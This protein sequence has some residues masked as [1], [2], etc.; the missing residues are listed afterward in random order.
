MRIPYESS[1]LFRV[2]TE[3]IFHH[4]DLIHSYLDDTSLAPLCNSFSFQILDLS[5]KDGN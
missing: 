1:T 4:T 3:R 2:L 5:K